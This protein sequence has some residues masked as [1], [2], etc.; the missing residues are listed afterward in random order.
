[1]H[2][3]GPNW[4]DPQYLLDTYGTAFFGI[5]LLIV[6]IECG[7]F[8]PILPGDS[9]LFAIGIFIAGGGSNTVGGTAAG[10]RNL[11]SGNANGGLRLSDSDNNLIAGNYIGTNAA[12]T[13]AISNA[14]G[15]NTSS[16]GNTIGGIAP[17][18]VVVE[19]GQEERRAAETLLGRVG[20]P[21]DVAEAVVY[22]AGA[23]YV[24]GT[25]LVVDGGRLLKSGG[26]LAP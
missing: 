24:T 14:V 17:G 10:A 13:N 3:L 21:A 15:V 19:P 2:A 16:T 7:L 12:G 4:M 6:F 20:S 11:I 23:A 25:T 26:R 22:L 9:L 1:M 5:S 8:F 18:A